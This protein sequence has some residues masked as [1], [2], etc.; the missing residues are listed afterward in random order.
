MSESSSPQPAFH[1]YAPAGADEGYRPPLCIVI[2]RET[3]ARGRSIAERVAE[4]LEWS[5]I[6]QES[7]EY[8]TQG[9][10]AGN[11]GRSVELS[12]SVVAWVDRRLHELNHDGT[13]ARQPQVTSLV[14]RILEAAATESRVILGRGAG[15]V[16]P[17][18]ARL[19]VKIV[20][21]LETRIAFIAQVNR[22]APSEARHFVMEKDQAREE[23]LAAKLGID[24][25]DMAQFDLVVNTE[26]FGVEASAQLIAAAAREKE[27]YL[28]Q[29]GRSERTWRVGMPS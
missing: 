29:F 1:G 8:L 13:L 28:D 19:H 15:R 4:L 22:L 7:L 25:S 23:F 9:P 5:Y 18:N 21:P 27:A 14:R 10:P 6:D 20:A 17:I 16:L 24:A 12:E 3:G 26:Q 11:D 2:S